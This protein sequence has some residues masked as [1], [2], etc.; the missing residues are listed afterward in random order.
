MSRFWKIIFLSLA[1]IFFFL[2]FLSLDGRWSFPD[3]QWDL[4]GNGEKI[5]VKPEHPIRQKF[6]ADRNNLSRI[7]ILFGRSYNKD[8]GGISLKLA[9]ESCQ[10]VL[11]EESFKRSAIQSEGYYDFK[12]AKIN[13]S[14]DQKFCLLVGFKPQNEKYK[15]LSM[16]LATGTFSENQMIDIG[17]DESSETK[18][19]A[20]AMRP[21]YQ[22]NSLLGNISE[23]NQRIS[24]YKPW[25][26]K[27]VYLHVVSFLFLLLTFFFVVLII[28]I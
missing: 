13:D 18:N 3:T 26:L 7:R 5:E 25:F 2:V 8:G 9:D 4:S 11:R 27:N 12:F 28:W 22:G 19:G 15:K 23:L 17:Q 24:Q 16:F 1:T 20:L 21:A 14:K 6:E 10:N